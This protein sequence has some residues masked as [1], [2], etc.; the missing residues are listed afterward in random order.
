MA[1]LPPRDSGFLFPSL[2]NTL[3]PGR[4]AR[5]A[6]LHATLLSSPTDSQT[7]RE[8]TVCARPL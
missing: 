3:A 8:R 1:P 2:E 6:R 4:S 7:T 5:Q